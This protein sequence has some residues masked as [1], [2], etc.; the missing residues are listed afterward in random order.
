MEENTDNQSTDADLI[1]ERINYLW[2]KT[3][4]TYTLFKR[5]TG[6]AIIAADFDGNILA[7]NEGARQMYGFEPKRIIGKQHMEIF[8]PDDFVESGGLQQTISSLMNKETIRYEGEKVRENGSRFP[9][10]ILFTVSRDLEGK[11]VGF[12]EIVEDL[13]EQ[14][15]TEKKIKDL[16]NILER[17]TVELE[18]TNIELQTLNRQLEQRRRE[19]EVAKIQAEAA[20]RA[21]SDFLANMSHEFRTPLNAVI[22]FSEILEDRMF[23]ELNEKQLEYVRD[24]ASS[25]QHL[26]SLVND[27]LDLAKVESGKLEL[28]PS[29]FSLKD[30]LNAA[31]SMLKE[32]AMKHGVK[33]AL[34]IMPDADI[35][36][37][38]DEKK[39]KQIMF[40]LLS[41][42]VKFTPEGGSVSVHAR[43]TRDDG[44]RTTDEKAS[45][46]S[47]GEAS[48]RPF[49]IE[50]SV[51]DTGI[52][53]KPEDINKLFKEF[54]QVESTY[55]K[56]Y[57]G[58]GLGL[59]LS[60][61]L[62]E[63]QGGKIWVESEFGKGSRFVFV[64]PM[65]PTEE[66]GLQA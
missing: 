29:G 20:S 65:K 47:A 66:Q 15:K 38:A 37:E 2:E 59:A 39:L 4:F 28:Q 6:Y 21:K 10:S 43:L 50:I 22:G 24:I 45:N 58:T 51:S 30:V 3:D 33:L 60:K 53:I 5:L 9:A 63:L 36:I 34:E 31:M 14:K 56:T 27:I 44:R 17:K 11:L 1:K 8:F 23:G 61:K 46:V 13:T 16:N 12:V 35:E 55:T 40:N 52:G 48:D 49:S 42:A 26:L 25:G 54:S 18:N 19:A 64:L 41:N 57:E 62:V 7:Y 32:K